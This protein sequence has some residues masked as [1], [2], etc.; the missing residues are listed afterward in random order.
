MVLLDGL[1]EVGGDPLK[2]KPLR[3]QVVRGVQQFAGRWCSAGQ[4]QPPGGDQPHRR[5]LG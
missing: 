3:A 5:L 4:V 2:G 1:D